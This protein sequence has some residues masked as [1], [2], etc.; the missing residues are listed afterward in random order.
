MKNGA[1]AVRRIVSNVERK[2]KDGGIVQ[3]FAGD[4]LNTA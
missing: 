3:S 1:G 2:S 4:S